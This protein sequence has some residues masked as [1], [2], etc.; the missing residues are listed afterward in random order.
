[1]PSSKSGVPGKPFLFVCPHPIEAKALASHL[2][3]CRPGKRPLK[4]ES[5]LASIL[6]SGEGGNRL[7]ESLSGLDLS[8]FSAVFLFGTAGSLSSEIPLGELFFCNPVRMLGK[9]GINSDFL[10]DLPQRPLVTQP[11]PVI[12]SVDRESLFRLSHAPLVDMEGWEFARYV[13]E[14]TIPWAI[15]RLV[16]D[17]PEEPHSFPFPARIREMLIASGKVLLK[18]LTECHNS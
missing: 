13:S 5:P 3:T 2:K 4:Y 1:M 8:A 11:A 15:F 17:T 9:T 6:I 12:S 10:I 18:L 7:L 14:R 16:S